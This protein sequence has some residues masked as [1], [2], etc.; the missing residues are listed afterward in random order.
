MTVIESKLKELRRQYSH[1]SEQLWSEEAKV[2]KP[3]HA[4]KKATQKLIEH[5]RSKQ[6]EIDDQRTK[7]YLKSI[8]K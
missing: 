4:N 8:D 1:V 2:T 5:Y 3:S 6:I 7:I